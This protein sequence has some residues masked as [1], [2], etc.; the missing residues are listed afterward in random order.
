MMMSVRLG[1]RDNL[2]KMKNKK[3]FVNMQRAPSY[4]MNF[5]LKTKK[6]SFV[7][8]NISNSIGKT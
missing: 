7:S 5:E 1:V 6:K 3:N 8:L 4:K 2:N